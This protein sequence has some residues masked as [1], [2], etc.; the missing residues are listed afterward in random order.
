MLPH[1]A[2]RDSVNLEREKRRKFETNV[3][4]LDCWDKKDESLKLCAG[5]LWNRNSLS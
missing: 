2:Q 5:I 3:E 4:I 1:G